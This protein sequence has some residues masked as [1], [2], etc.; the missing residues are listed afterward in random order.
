MAHTGYKGNPPKQDTMEHRMVNHNERNDE[1][2]RSGHRNTV[3]NNTLQ[4][5]KQ[6]WYTSSNAI[7]RKAIKHSQQNT[8]YPIK[9]R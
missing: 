1:G 3:K 8:Q 2:E 4:G 5:Y 7:E 9:G 6:N